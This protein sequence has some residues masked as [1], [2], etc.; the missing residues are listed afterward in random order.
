MQ[1]LNIGARLDLEINLVVTDALS[2]FLFTTSRNAN[3]S[4]VREWILPEKVFFVGNVMIVTLLSYRDQARTLGT[5][6]SLGLEPQGYGPLTLHGPSDADVPQTLSGILDALVTIQR[7]LPILSP[8]PRTAKR[9]E[10]CG[11]THRL[12]KA[13][14]FH[15]MELMGYLRFLDLMTHARI[16]LINSGS[17][18]EEAT[19]LGVPCLTLLESTERPITISQGINKLM[20]VDPDRVVAETRQI[21]SGKVRAGRTPELRDV[22]ADG[23]IVATLRVELA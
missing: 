22:H 13:T 23:R 11:F 1:L 18:Q 15:I 21:L 14:D 20:G 9:I 10:E 17:F 8:P 3:N 7:D 19:I 4:L 16:V 6:G 2:D 5:P 12:K